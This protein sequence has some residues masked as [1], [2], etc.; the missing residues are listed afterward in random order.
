MQIALLWL[1][2]EKN[3]TRESFEN[4]RFDIHQVQLVALQYGNAFI[5]EATR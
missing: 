2:L 1:S 5:N 4:L 3:D